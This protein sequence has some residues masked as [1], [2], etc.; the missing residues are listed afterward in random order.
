[1]FGETGSYSHGP[2]YHGMTLQLG[3]VPF[4]VAGPG[5]KD[6]ISFD[7]H[8]S[9]EVGSTILDMFN[10]DATCGYGKSFKKEVMK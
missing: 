5:V 1:M 8:S 4:I 10:I 9:I 6:S 3:H 7:Y 2:Y